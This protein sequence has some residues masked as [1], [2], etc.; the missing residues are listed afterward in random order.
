MTR[1]LPLFT[2]CLIALSLV[3]CTKSEED[4]RRAQRSTGGDLKLMPDNDPKFEAE[5]V[6]DQSQVKIVAARTIT[7]EPLGHVPRQVK[8]KA[9]GDEPLLG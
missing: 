7:Y 5:Y 9:M 4:Y 2:I 1:Q 6:S 8:V 3:R